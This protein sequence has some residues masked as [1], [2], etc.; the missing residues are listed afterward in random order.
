MTTEILEMLLRHCVQLTVVLVLVVMAIRIWGKNRPHLSRV[1]LIL[2]AVKCITPPIMSGSLGIFSH[3]E[4]Y[5]AQLLNSI[6]ADTLEESA[7]VM[8]LSATAMVESVQLSNSSTGEFAQAPPYEFVES[9]ISASHEPVTTHSWQTALLTVWLCGVGIAA[10]IFLGRWWRLMNQLKLS[11][12]ATPAFMKTML[13]ELRQQFHVD[14][15]RVRLLV[16]T[17]Q[18]GPA[19]LGLVRPVIVIPDCLTTSATG[20]RLKL[21]LAHELVHIRRGDLWV[22]L[23]LVLA[24]TVL[25][26]HPAVWLLRGLLNR[27]SERSCDE[28]VVAGLNCDP[29]D[30]ARGLLHVLEQNQLQPIPVFPGV[31]PVEIT[32]ERMERIMRNRNGFRRRTPWWCWLVMLTVAIVIL[33]GAGFAKPDEEESSDATSSA[34][35]DKSA[36]LEQ[37]L[38]FTPITDAKKAIR[39]AAHVNQ[40]GLNAKPS[41]GQMAKGKLNAEPPTDRQVIYSVAKE[42]SIE[43]DI[44]EFLQTSR[45][46][47]HIVKEQLSQVAEKPRFYPLVGPAKRIHAHFK[48]TVYFDKKKA[49]AYLDTQNLL[50]VGKLEADR[51]LVDKTPRHLL[52]QPVSLHFEKTPL[53][54]A[55]A[56]IAATC[57]VNLALDTRATEEAGVAKTQRVSL[58]VDGIKLRNAL[59]LIL[60]PLDLTFIQNGEVIKVTSVDA[61][62]PYSTRA[63]NVADLVVPIE[64]Q[65]KVTTE[66]GIAIARG[67]NNVDTTKAD[68]KSLIDLITSTIAPDTWEDSGSG[69]IQP[70]EQTLSLVIRQRSEIHEQIVDLLGQLRRLQDT[71]IQ[72]RV[73]VVEADSKNLALYSLDDGIDF[74]SGGGVAIV[75][76]A[77]AN[78]WCSAMLKNGAAT[79]PRTSVMLFQGQQFAYTAITKG[80]TK[81]ELRFT[82]TLSSNNQLVR[83]SCSVAQDA[84]RE[85]KENHLL[86]C[87]SGDTLVLDLSVQGDA[88]SIKNGPRRFLLADVKVITT[89]AEEELILNEN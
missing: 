9:D 81:T 53:S 41:S 49:T 61:A 69:R 31:R 29:A 88:S 60:E 8:P 17:G 2:V 23:L 45:G 80:R 3:A 37:A 38:R 72:M 20:D 71:M 18:Q 66:N 27:E 48:C 52:D 10:L 58:D 68:F 28:E 43:G 59:Q 50:R 76:S 78:K 74:R 62:R 24:R 87:A 57:G 35:G 82:P 67:G 11:E 13:T 77:A 85:E 4:T 54:K 36:D 22:S 25:W 7:A 33:P 55:L 83:V 16:T 51:I 6:R 12:T 14:T 75:S 70:Y 63:Y 21:I 73:R 47:I 32:S 64:S 26:F 46:D 40:E 39:P 56:E 89:T 79:S 5:T 65:V 42:L 15:N 86:K 30:Y 84:S 19:V 34:A 44:D 1:L